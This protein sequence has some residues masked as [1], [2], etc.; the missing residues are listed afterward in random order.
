[1]FCRQRKVAFWRTKALLM[2]VRED[3]GSVIQI[4]RFIS[5]VL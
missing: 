4:V 2:G 1:M 3:P 5:V